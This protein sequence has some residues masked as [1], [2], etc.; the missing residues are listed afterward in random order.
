MHH[1]ALKYLSLCENVHIKTEKDMIANVK[2]YLLHLLCVVALLGGMT[3]C[4]GF[5]INWGGGN[6]NGNGSGNGSG[7]GEG[8][9]EEV[10]E[11]AGCW[12]LVNLNE[13]DVD[14]DIYINFGKDGKFV[15][16]QR[17]ETLEFTVFN[18]TYTIDEEN[19]VISGVYDDGTAWLCDYNYVVDKEA[20]TLTLTDVNN[21]S[22]VAVYEWATLPASATVK[23]R[24]ASVS[25]V[26]PL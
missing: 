7:N 11:L 1:F 17:T 10:I 3:A 5:T 18:G 23:T 14:V 19:A 6:G 21:E 20:K 24:S 16:Y 8:G 25:D 4:E 12:H 9:K 22:E 13:M 2:K 26:K 15:I